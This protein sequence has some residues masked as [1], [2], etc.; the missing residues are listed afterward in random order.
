MPTSTSSTVWTVHQVRTGGVYASEA[1]FSDFDAACR[2]ARD[3]SREPRVLAAAVTVLL[4]DEP[5][6]ACDKPRGFHGEQALFVRGT[7]QAS[8]WITDDKSCYRWGESYHGH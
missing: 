3:L 7:P 2:Y 5:G 4:V 1:G 6:V 8:H